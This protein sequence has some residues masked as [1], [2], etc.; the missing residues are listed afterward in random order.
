MFAL[1]GSYADGPTLGAKP[2]FVSLV[3]RSL[4]DPDNV[5]IGR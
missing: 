5:S 3:P 2:H 1:C 4:N